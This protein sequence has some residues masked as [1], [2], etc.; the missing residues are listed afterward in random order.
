MNRRAIAL[1]FPLLTAG[2]LAGVVILVQ[3]SDRVGWTDPRVISTLILW[4]A[5]AVLI[6]LRFGHH[7]RG[8]QVALMTIG[9][10]VLLLCCLFLSHPLAQGEAR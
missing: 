5:F 8:R 6:Y 10:F 9:T 7:L 1:A 2:V 3:G 4:L